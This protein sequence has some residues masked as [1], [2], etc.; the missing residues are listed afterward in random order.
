MN[1]IV[2]KIRNGARINFL[3][4]VIAPTAYFLLLRGIFFITQ[5]KSF[6]YTIIIYLA[7]ILVLVLGLIINSFIARKDK[8][9]PWL[10][11]FIFTIL[12]GVAFVP[13][14]LILVPTIVATL[15]IVQA[16]L[17]LLASYTFILSVPQVSAFL[18]MLW[19]AAT[20]F[21]SMVALFS[22]GIFVVVKGNVNIIKKIGKA[23][24]VANH[25]SSGDYLLIPW[26]LWGLHWRVMIGSNLW[27]W[28][29]FSWFFT[30]IGLPVLREKEKAEA[31]TGTMFRSE[32][33][34]NSHDDA[35]VCAFPEGTRTRDTNVP[36]LPFKKGAFLLA[37]KTGV[38]IIPVVVIGMDKWRKPGKQDTASF[39]R[40]NFTIIGFLKKIYGI[41]KSVKD[42][43][44]RIFK[45]GINPGKVIVIY[46]DPVYPKDY[47]STDD[48]MSKVSE[49]ICDCYE[50]NAY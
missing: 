2:K 39:V 16:V 42:L 11:K 33:H 14:L 18:S 3:I 22:V 19:C 45:E 37:M 44:L 9:R 27:K 12:F 49:L 10:V 50:K 28:P 41:P 36:L 23:I 31:R 17:F 21:C 29:I 13:V 34:L 5:H 48:L 30:K 40:K 15:S 24:I 32:A 20:S 8:E 4:L 7:F 6:K 25:R 38:P 1:A 43:T 46:L 26:L 35:K 47:A